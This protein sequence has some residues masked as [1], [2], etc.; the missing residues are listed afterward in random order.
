MTNEYDYIVVGAGPAGSVV[1][2]RL[3]ENWNVLLL[4]A[5]D[6]MADEWVSVPGGFLRL[7]LEPSLMWADPTLPTAHLADRT[8]KLV[9]GKGMGGSS[10]INGM[11]YVRGHRED[12]D[13]WAASGYTGWS[14]EDVFRVF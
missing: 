7:L 5:G 1:A 14:W 8:I 10:A 12:Y 9:Q 2:N 6:D 13:G 3:S 11:L 4:E